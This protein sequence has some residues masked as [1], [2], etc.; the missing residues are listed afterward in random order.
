[1]VFAYGCPD[2]KQP[3]WCDAHRRAFEYFE[4]VAQVIVPDN[5]LFMIEGVVGV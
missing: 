4:G 3:A 1:M 5:G 2:E